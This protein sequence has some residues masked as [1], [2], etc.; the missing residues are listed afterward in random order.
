MDIQ[1]LK[2][3]CWNDDDSRT[4]IKQPWSEGSHSFATSGHLLI[5]VARIDGIQENKAAPELS[6][7]WPK[8]QPEQWYAVPECEEKPAI[9]CPKCKGQQIKPAVCPECGGTGN[10]EWSTYYNDYTCDCLSCDGTGKIDVCNK[11]GG[12][13]KVE[14]LSYHPVGPAKFQVKYLHLLS[15]LPNCEIGP[16]DK[17]GP[18]WIRFDGGVGLIMPFVPDAGLD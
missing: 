7:V 17:T 14:V 16:M 1:T 3:F 15:T 4:N 12:S 6:R 18:A 2:K 13:G 11:C 9:D 10:V 5:K 8:Q